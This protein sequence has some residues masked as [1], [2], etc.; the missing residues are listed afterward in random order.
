MFSSELVSGKS[1]NGLNG[2]FAPGQALE[3]LLSGSGLVATPQSGGGYSIALE[4]QGVTTLPS[5]K[6]SADS[7]GNTTEG[8]NSYTTRSM[9]TATRLGLS[10]R[11][12]PQS[13]SVVSRQ[14]IDDM[15][16]ESL[17]DV[18]DTVTGISSTNQDSSR[19]SF[20]ARGFNINHYQIDG[21]PTSWQ[22]GW[23]AGESQIDTVIYDLSLIHI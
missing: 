14:M 5:V 10:I 23:S 18:V 6:V 13:V 9:N 21:V 3:H 16:L 19:N 22:S 7:I 2:H 17:T 12:T 4:R 15:Q 20:S 8:T 11:E 1:S